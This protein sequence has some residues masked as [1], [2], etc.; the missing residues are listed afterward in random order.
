MFCFARTPAHMPAFGSSFQIGPLG[1]P[2]CHIVMSHDIIVPNEFQAAAA[3]ALS[4]GAGKSTG[5][6]IRKSD[7][8]VLF[9]CFQVL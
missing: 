1:A 8:H 5:F 9:C 3:A 2:N 7:G 6:S 4:A